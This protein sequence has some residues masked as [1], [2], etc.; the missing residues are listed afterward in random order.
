[1]LRVDMYTTVLLL[2]SACCAVYVLCVA[3]RKK[4]NGEDLLLLISSDGAWELRSLCVEASPARRDQEDAGGKHIYVYWSVLSSGF[5][6]S[7]GPSTSRAQWGAA[8]P[9]AVLAVT[10]PDTLHHVSVGVGRGMGSGTHDR[11]ALLQQG[12]VSL[13]F[14]EYRHGCG[15]ARVRATIHRASGVHVSLRL[16]TSCNRPTCSAF[17]R[18]SFVHTSACFVHRRTPV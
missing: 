1:M 18:L 8:P 14:F 10:G 5:L 2:Y 17:V 15:N 11:V 13:L 9:E 7:S 6:G 3:P 4:G 12:M 16:S